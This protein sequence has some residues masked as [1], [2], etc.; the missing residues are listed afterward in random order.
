MEQMVTW[1]SPGKIVFF[2]ASLLLLGGLLVL[3]NLVNPAIH[4]ADPN[5]EKAIR[6]KIDQPTSP[7]TR[8]DLL[9]ITELD[10][11]GRD[12][13]RLE[14]IEALRRLAVLNLGE[15]AVEDLSPLAK[16]SM[17]SELN[18]QNNQI[19]DLEAIRFDQI[20]HLPVRSLNLRDNSIA[21][22]KPLSDFYSL[23]ELNLRIL[24]RSP[25]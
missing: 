5:L 24:S 19:S 9:A 10:A 7:L 17:L 12:I 11:S 2:L 16:L 3:A 6:E 4:F 25:V 23:R 8:L 15:N 13:K 1:K 21:N 14:G 20:K 18:L 22:I